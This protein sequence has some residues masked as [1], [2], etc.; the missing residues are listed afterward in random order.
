MW[1][2]TEQVEKA[3]KECFITK[4]LIT[5]QKYFQKQLHFYL[6]ISKLCMINSHGN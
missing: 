1:Y 2:T 4:Q 3:M 5:K 6:F